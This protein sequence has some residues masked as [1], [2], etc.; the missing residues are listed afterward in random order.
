[1]Q[2]RVL[3]FPIRHSGMPTPDKQKMIESL[4][5]LSRQADSFIRQAQILK[6]KISALNQA[7][8]KAHDIM[9]RFGEKPP[10]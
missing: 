8:I 3:R 10:L 7:C 6:E 9:E 4:D 2:C 5:R 1:M